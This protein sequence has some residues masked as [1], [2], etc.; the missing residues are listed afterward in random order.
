M[1]NL[2]TTFYDYI[3]RK[4]NQQAKMMYKQYA[5]IN[6]KICK[7]TSRKFFLKECK[8][9]GLMPN[10]TA[11]FFKCPAYLVKENSR[12]IQHIQRIAINAGSKL[13]KVEIDDAIDS[14]KNLRKQN[15]DYK[16]WIVRSTQQ[17][18]YEQFFVSQKNYFYGKL[19]NLKKTSDKKINNL[20][21]KQ[22]PTMDT[23]NLNEN[24]L[25]NLTDVQIP[26]EMQVLLSYGEKFSVHE[27]AHKTN[28]FH[29]IA[30]I[31]NAICTTIE[32]ETPRNVARTDIAAMVKS[33]VAHNGTPL[34]VKDKLFNDL[35]SKTTRFIKNY[36]AERDAK[37]FLIARSDK[38]NQTVV[39]YR[40]DYHNAMMKMISDRSSYD[41]IPSDITPKV[42]EEVKKVAKEMLEKSFINKAEY[43]NLVMTNARAPRI[44]GLVK[45]HKPNTTR[46]SFKLRPV[47]S[48]IGSALYKLSAF[49]GRIIRNSIVSPFNVANSYIFQELIMEER[50]PDDYEMISMD[51]V[52]LFTC[53]PQDFLLECIHERW[54]NISRHTAIDKELFV[55]AVSVCLN[56]SYFVYQGRY[57]SQKSG[58]P[59]GAPISTAICDLAMEVILERISDL[60]PFDIP[61]MMKYVDDILL[62]CP[63]SLKDET[64]EIFNCINSDVQFTIETEKDRKLA[65]LDHELTRNEDGSIDT[66]FYMKP[67]SSGRIINFHSNHSMRLKINTAVGLIRRVF[68]FSSNKSDS[69]KSARVMSLLRKNCYPKSIVNKLINEYK[70]SRNR[71]PA[72]RDKERKIAPASVPY[73]RGLTDAIRRKISTL[74]GG[75]TIGVA[76]NKT[77]S[78]VFSKLKDPL[79]EEEKTKSI[80]GVP[81]ENCPKS[82]VGLVWRQF[83]NKRKQQHITGQKS[84]QKNRNKKNRT[85]LEDHVVDENH[86]FDFD[87]LKILDSCSNYNKLKTLE[88][89]HIFANDTVNKRSDVSNAIHQYA[90]LLHQL[91]TKNLL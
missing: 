69:E 55:K 15:D 67:N 1:A 8:R 41:E 56:H 46:E 91:K 89:L 30:D 82:Y 59:M 44:Y 90:G 70:N 38:C 77:A 18:D 12:Y 73:I 13:L 4:Y 40:E 62:C 79:K 71:P 42:M 58:T 68:G 86:Q 17:C 24:W 87:S 64:L 16:N 49:L 83:V 66:E 2:P 3:G 29:L 36:H 39:L 84:V 7:A 75:K 51:V 88:M 35:L 33:Y 57:F 52:S 9:I 80:Y 6:D 26:T 53:L 22:I 85:A 81:C 60:M 5:D 37:E 28:F 23:P 65:Y 14:L 27:E 11:H 72:E 43:M 78:R 31:E 45:T 48:Y 34:S 74:S 21:L 25:V 76:S 10:H 20:K 32:G 63:R 50:I 19:K 61:F 54:E 47:V